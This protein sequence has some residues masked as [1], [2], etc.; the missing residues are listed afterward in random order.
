MCIRDRNKAAWITEAYSTWIKLVYTQIKAVTWFH[1]A[2][3]EG[4]VFTD[5]RINSSISALTAYQTAIADPYFLASVPATDVAV[6]NVIPEYFALEQNY[7]NPFNPT[8]KIKFALPNSGNVKLVVYNIFG[9]KINILI[10]SYLSAGI[11]E[12]DFSA[13]DLSS[14]VYLYALEFD[15]KREMKKMI[16]QK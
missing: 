8:T 14:G 12:V 5:W 7:P 3:L 9:E 1:I 11:H 16:L 2:K 13:N 4:S 6:E 15:G 10:Q